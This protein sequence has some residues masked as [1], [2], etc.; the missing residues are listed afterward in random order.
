M[1]LD[2]RDKRENDRVLIY[3][4]ILGL[5]PRTHRLSFENPG[6]PFFRPGAADAR[7]GVLGVANCHFDRARLVYDFDWHKQVLSVIY[8]RTPDFAGVR[9]VVILF[10]GSFV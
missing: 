3:F 9:I 10:H 2:S 5:V 1:F 6:A 4:V 8:L 7:Y